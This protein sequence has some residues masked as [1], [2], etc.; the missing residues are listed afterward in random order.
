ML[1]SVGG[2]AGKNG[3]SFMHVERKVERHQLFASLVFLTRSFDSVDG[4]NPKQ[5]L[6]IYQTR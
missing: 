6:G 4:R 3:P 5:P 1:P 2:T